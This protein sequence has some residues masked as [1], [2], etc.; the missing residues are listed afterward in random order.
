MYEMRESSMRYPERKGESKIEE[1]RMNS[2][3][4]IREIKEERE[5]KSGWVGK[6]KVKTNEEIA[7]WCVCVFVENE[8]Y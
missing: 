3:T 2:I 7:I 8:I 4:I 1:S 6:R 5:S